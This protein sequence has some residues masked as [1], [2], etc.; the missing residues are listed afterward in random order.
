M[1]PQTIYG[2][3]NMNVYAP[4]RELQELGVIGNLS[5]MTPEAAFIKMAWLLSNYSHDEAKKLFSQNL[6]GEI[7]KRTDNSFTIKN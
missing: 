2:R 3:I 7:T 5:D 1:A 4:G 6:K